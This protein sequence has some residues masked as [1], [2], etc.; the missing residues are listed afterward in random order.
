FDGTA[1]FSG[2]PLGNY[3]V[4]L[5]PD[6]AKRLRMRLTKPIAVVVKS[7]SGFGAD[8]QGEVMFEPRAQEEDAQLSELESSDVHAIG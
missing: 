6:Q 2:V 7:D 1:I 5:D 3:R 4:E 8:V